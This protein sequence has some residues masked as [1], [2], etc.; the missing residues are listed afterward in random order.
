M[1]R[2]LFSFFSMLAFGAVSA[3]A[4][5]AFLPWMAGKPASETDAL[6][7]N[8]L[9]LGLVMGLFLGTLT[10]YNWADVPR[11]VVTWFLVRERQL[12]YYA[13]IIVCGALLLF[14]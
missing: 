6:H 11:R 3:A 10:R 9:L 14:Y 13:L 8:S 12:F 7:L 4:L 5:V 2:P 1:L